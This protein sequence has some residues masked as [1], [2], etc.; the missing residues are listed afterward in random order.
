[1]PF[2]GEL[3]QVREDERDWEGAAGAPVARL[4]PLAP[5]A[6]RST[7]PAWRVGSTGP[8][9]REG[10]STSASARRGAI[11]RRDRDAPPRLHADSLVRKLSVKPGQRVLPLA[12]ARARPSLR[13]GLLRRSDAVPARDPRDH[14]RRPDQGCRRAAREGRPA[15]HRTTGA[16][17]CSAGPTAAKIDALESRARRIESELGE[18]GGQIAGMQREQRGIRERL[19]SLS[20]LK[21]YTEFREIDWQA[22]AA[23]IERLRDEGA[24]AR[25]PNPTCSR[26]SVRNS[27]GSRNDWRPPRRR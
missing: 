21:E 2:A 4:R 6:R 5:G 23:E 17:T 16:A 14:P 27:R 22:L 15:P 11:G 20:G 3:L 12:G 7:T 25:G 9:S 10:S 19:D 1:M 8:T 24:A 18:L 13:R 26:D